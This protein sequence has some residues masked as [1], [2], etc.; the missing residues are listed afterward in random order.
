MSH[1]PKQVT[2]QGQRQGI[3]NYTQLL[4]Q[5]LKCYMAKS[6]DKRKNEKFVSIIKSTIKVRK[7]NYRMP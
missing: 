4:Q 3:E 7:E 2:S 1:W 5:E 6:L